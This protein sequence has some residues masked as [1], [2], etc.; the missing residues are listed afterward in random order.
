MLSLQVSVKD[1]TF[2][3]P[4]GIGR[5][6]IGSGPGS[7]LRI[8]AEGVEPAHARIE[9]AGSGYKILDLETRIGTRVNGN[10]IAQVRLELGD[11]IEIGPAVILV[12][13]QVIREA[14]PK[15]VLAD[16]A[17]SRTPSP[18]GGRHAG[19]RPVSR[20]SLT[21]RSVP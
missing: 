4:L 18:S 1:Q 14:T 12:G 19:I 16:T 21:G 8:E 6:V 15:D 2:L 5:F 11:R 20:S 17:P 3:K 13:D 10:L 7:D 9:P